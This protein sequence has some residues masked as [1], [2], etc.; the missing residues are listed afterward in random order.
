MIWHMRSFVAYSIDAQRKYRDPVSYM[1][2]YIELTL[3]R[4][5]LRTWQSRTR[6]YQVTLLTQIMHSNASTVGRAAQD[7]NVKDG[8]KKAPKENSISGFTGLPFCLHS[9]HS[10]AE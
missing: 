1:L 6:I 4:L 7:A 5:S 2:A 9:I 8:N 3:M 10:R